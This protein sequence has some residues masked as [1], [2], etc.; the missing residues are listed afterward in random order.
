MSAAGRPVIGPDRYGERLTAAARLTA[1]AGLEA[2]LIGVGSDLRYLT[3]YPALALERLTMLVVPARG[4]SFLIA[5]RLEVGAARACPAVAAGLIEVVTWD[6]TEDAVARLVERLSG[7]LGLTSSSAIGR[8]AISDHL[9]AMFVLRLQAALPGASFELASAITRQLR[10]VKDPEELTLLRLAAEAADRVIA[11]VSRGPLVGRTEAEVSREI[12]D[13]LVDEGHELAEFAIVGSGPNSASPHHDASDRR[14][15]A[16]EPIVLDIGGALDGYCSDTTR[17]IW[18]RGGD[19]A[20][21]REAPDPDFALFYEVLRSAQAA[22]TAAVRPGI[23]CQDLDA[24][25]RGIIEAAG[26]G[27]QFFHRLGHGIGLEAHEDPYLVAGNLEP[28]PAG[29]AFSIEPGIYFEGRFGARI[30]DIVVCGP[31]GPIVL[32]QSPTELQVVSG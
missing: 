19:G 13:R 8:V 30:E 3:G 7:C 9:W 24:T 6:E 16:G 5:P 15:R 1:G 31:E 12:G 28:L 18:V 29:S 4:A 23:A 21:R 2:L 14:I 27:P 10:M 22:A 11:Q 26:Y 20:G 25:A 17:T 32:N